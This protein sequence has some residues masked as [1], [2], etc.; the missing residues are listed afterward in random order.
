MQAKTKR[1]LSLLL[2]IVVIAL[3]IAIVSGLISEEI[4]RRN[5]RKR[6]PQIGQSIDIGGRSLNLYCSGEGSPAVVFDSGAGAPGYSWS[7]IQP[8]IA[9][10][11]RA[12]WYD[13]AGEGWSDAG[14][15][16]RTSAAN[17]QDLHEL[18]RRAGVAPP[19]ILVGH[20]YGGLNARVYNGMYPN[21]VA[22]M[23]LV[24]SAHEDESKRAPKF[25]LGK[26]LPKSLWYPLHLLTQAAL[27]V[28]LIRLFN[29]SPALP[30]DPAQRTRSQILAALRQ[31]PKAVAT[32]SDY[33][34]SP[35]SYAQAHAAAG[36]GDKPLIVL[37]RGKPPSPSGN[38]EMDR[39]SAAYEQVWIHEMQPQLVRLST[40]GRQVI[41]SKSGHG[42]P[43]EAPEAVI[44]AV[45]EVLTMSPAIRE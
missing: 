29:S 43:E 4:G 11:T 17:A 7:N 40:R 5:D 3:V 12:C 31:Q 21:E 28:G 30:A 45:R 16:P 2:K 13:R 41:V 20:S 35:E 33:V 14:P 19:Y 6:N 34:T 27:R 44:D 8:E 18:L 38:P 36:L 23:V 22:G 32:L 15:F 1:I 24:D 39:E 25:M 37:T 10:F 9:K 26:T 42:I